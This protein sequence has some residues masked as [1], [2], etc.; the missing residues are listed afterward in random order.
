MTSKGERI[1]LESVTLEKDLGVTID[2]DLKFSKH[3]SIQVNKANNLLALILRGFTM[4]DK[5]S[6]PTLY[7]SII[8]PHLE[9]GNVVW[10]PTLKGDEEQLEKV[11]RRATKLIPELQHLAYCDRLRK[12]D[13]PSL[14]Y[15]RARGDM[16]DC[17][18]HLTRIYNF[19]QSRI[20]HDYCVVGAGPSGL[21]MGYFLESK[22]RD[23][24]VFERSNTP[25]SFFETYPRHRKLISINKRHTGQVNPEFNLRHDWNSLLSHDPDLLLTKYTRQMFP[26]ADVLVKYLRDYEQKLGI[27]VL[28]NTSVTNIR[29]VD[30]VTVS[31]GHRF[32]MEDQ[33]GQQYQCRTLIMATGVGQPNIPDMEGIQLAHGYENMSLDPEDYE[34]KTV[35]I[36]GR[37]NTAFEIAT[38]LYGSTNYIHMLSSSRARLSWSTHYVGDLRAVNNDLLDTYQL[39]SLDAIME[40]DLEKL[41]LFKRG[42][43]IHITHADNDFLPRRVDNT[44]LRDPYDIVIRALGFKFD[45]SI[46][47]KTE[48]TRGRLRASKFP[49]IYHNYESVD[50]SG[51][52]YAGTA[53]HSLDFRKSAGGF[54]HGFRY[55]D[56]QS[57]QY[58]EE[59]PINLLHQLPQRTGIEGSEVMVIVMEYGHNFSRPGN[60]IFRTDRTVRGPCEAHKSN[61][62]HPVIYY[63]S[64]LP[65]ESMMKSRGAQDTLPRPDAL[66]HIVEDFTAFWTS[67]HSHILPLRRFLEHVTNTDLRSFFSSSC[68]QAAMTFTNVPQSCVR[69]YMEGRGLMS[70]PELTDVVSRHGLIDQI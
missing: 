48:I 53:S 26:H 29:P 27:N 15:R 7:K 10:H 13:L 68:F 59:F 22:G 36:L 46:F 5:V 16:I 18:K 40:T 56:G 28:Y 11:Q 63:Y 47:N 3:V 62:L 65:T 6:L 51:M 30:D 55:T 39:K 35:L 25:G 24:V 1:T 61:F 67:Q 23:Y 2:C 14:Y 43:K 31:D 34:G 32:L 33:R 66:H 50:H 17:Y 57:V 20:Y 9:Y 19:A 64:S 60:D 44:A 8:R 21:Q 37:G 69:G 45:S 70:T 52:F 12:L 38:S 54:I 41:A 58:L 49:T 42:D 4:L